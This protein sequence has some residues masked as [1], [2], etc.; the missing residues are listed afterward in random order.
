MFV[1]I[2]IV[3]VVSMFYCSQGAFEVNPGGGDNL[4]DTFGCCG[5][6]TLF[7][8]GIVFAISIVPAV[9]IWI[10]SFFGARNVQVLLSLELLYDLYVFVGM[11][12]TRKKTQL[13]L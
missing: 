9:L 2:P 1:V 10:V 4:G 13:G 5:M 3:V 11:Y 7:L 12:A 8:M 6:C